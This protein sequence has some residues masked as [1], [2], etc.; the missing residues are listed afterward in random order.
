MRRMPAT[1]TTGPSVTHAQCWAHTRRTFERALDSDPQAQHALA[2]IGDL[3]KAEADIRKQQLAGAAKHAARAEHA[4]PAVRA[5]WQWCDDQC[6]RLDLEPSHPLAKAIAYALERK[7]ALEVF[8]ADPAVPIDTNH[9]ERGLRPIPMGKKNWL[10]C[11]TEVGAEHVGIIQSL[12]STCRL[13]GVDPYT[14]LVDVLQRV[15]I[16]PAKRVAELTPRRWKAHFAE[17]PL[18]SDI[19]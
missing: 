3:Y 8:L 9:L 13:H 7:A 11:W 2:L 18:R 16:H 14:Y 17:H 10:F 19:D 4:K 12:I 1:P 5:F 6:Q 15:G